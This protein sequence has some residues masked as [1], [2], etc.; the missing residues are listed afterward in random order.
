[1]RA[2]QLTEPTLEAF[3]AT[4]LPDPS[5][6]HG[7]VLLRLRAASLNFVDI[8]VAAGN[9]PVSGFPLIPVADG[10][11]EVVELGTGVTEVSVGDRVVPHAKP[12]WVGG[13]ITEVV[14]TAMRGVTLPGSLAEYAVLPANALVPTP[15]HLNDVAA[16]TLPIAA[17][18]AWN[19]LRAGQVRPG[20]IVL[21]LGTGGV[22]IFALQLAKAAGATVIITSSS[23][24]KLERA[25]ELG[26]DMTVNYKRTP[27]WDTEVLKLT[28]GR[29][30]DLVI[31][32]GGADTFG[33]SLNV[34]ACGATVFVIGF[35]SGVRAS[36]DLL[37][38]ITKALNVQGKNTGTVADLRDAARA[39]A[40]QR[41]EP[42]VD[43]VFDIDDTAKAYAHVA[44]SGRHFGKV[45]IRH[46]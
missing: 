37:P 29:G 2:I 8:A 1:M 31:E 13:P 41:I 3:H 18:T 25:R 46:W 34:A 10:A 4:T 42:V 17:T 7:E 16:S 32:T 14:S 40:A 23:D 11:G 36:I 43:R 24:D 12:R 38:I 9:Y 27:D 21:L 45:A 19:G 5:P 33:R 22:S 44:A 26:A 6:G 20:S 39:I 28:D 15:A 30:V 35:L